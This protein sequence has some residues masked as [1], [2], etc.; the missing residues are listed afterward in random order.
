[1][2]SNCDSGVGYADGY[3]RQL[4]GVAKVFIGGQPAPVIGRV[5]MDSITVDVT[6]FDQQSLHTGTASLVHADY[7][8]QKMAN[9]IGTIPYEI[10]TSLG[11]RAERHYQGGG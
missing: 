8:V 5:S 6:D 7:R 11:H 9:D 3:R 1:M 10:M 2:T 4:G